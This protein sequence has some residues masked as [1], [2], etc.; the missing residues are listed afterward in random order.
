MAEVVGAYWKQDV[1]RFPE[2]LN[3]MLI[4][5]NDMLIGKIIQHARTSSFSVSGFSSCFGQCDS[6]QTNDPF[7]DCSKIDTER[8]FFV[9]GMLPDPSFCSYVE[10]Q[11]IASI[12]VYAHLVDLKTRSSLR[13]RS[14]VNPNDVV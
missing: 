1:W 11:K 4:L 3:K 13:D 7:L 14:T 5:I 10:S 2:E 9:W 6:T 12:R 8:F